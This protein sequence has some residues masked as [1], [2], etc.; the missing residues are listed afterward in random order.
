MQNEFDVFIKLI[1]IEKIRETSLQPRVSSNLGTAR[2]S[3]LVEQRLGTLVGRPGTLDSV[4]GT[5]G[6]VVAVGIEGTPVVAVGTAGK[7]V[8]VV[9]MADTQ[10]VAVEEENTEVA[11]GTEDTAAVGKED[12]VPEK[13]QEHFEQQEVGVVPALSLDWARGLE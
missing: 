3:G 1:K 9:G 13:P 12:T 6:K 4:A 10:A 5:Q 7:V 8:V 2:E 11:A